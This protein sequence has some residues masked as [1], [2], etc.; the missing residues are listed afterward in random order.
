MI[1]ANMGSKK[2]TRWKNQI[3]VTFIIL[4]LIG[5]DFF[6]LTLSKKFLK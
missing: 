3:I 4:I 1:I 6:L 5:I 2:F